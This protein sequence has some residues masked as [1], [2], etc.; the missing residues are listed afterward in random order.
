MLDNFQ[1][2]IRRIQHFLYCPHRWGLMEIGNMW[3]EN[4]YVTKANILHSKVHEHGSRTKNQVLRLTD[5]PVFN[6]SEE[7]NLYGV[8]DTLELYRDE[9]GVK[10][11]G[12]EGNYRLVLVEYKPTASA[13][14]D[15][16]E[17]DLIQIFAQKICVDYIFNCKSEAAVY[18]G[19]TRKRIDLCVNKDYKRLDSILRETLGKMRYYSSRN[20]IPEKNPKQRCNGCSMRDVCIP[21]LPKTESIVNRIRNTNITGE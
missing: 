21:K 15:Y 17:E 13:N 16:R 8:A 3:S 7:Y 12:R 5:V 18:Y 6:D 9:D 2:N 4:A 10:I 11:N 20:E 1:I 19:N 14:I